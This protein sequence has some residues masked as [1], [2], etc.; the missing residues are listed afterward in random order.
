MERITADDMDYWV[1]GT[2]PALLILH[3]GGASAEALLG[4]A[5]LVGHG[6]RV[7]VPNLAGYGRSAPQDPNQPAMAAHLAVVE[8]AFALCDGPIDLIG[9]S[10]GGFMALRAASRQPERVRR[11]V[12]IEP[13]CFGSLHTGDPLDAAAL[14][15]DRAAI[16][17][18]VRLVD[19]HEVEA[20]VAA[21]I[22][23]WG[24]APWDK[25]PERIRARL[26]ALGRQ[27]RREAFE[28]SYDE[29]PATAYAALGDRTLLL[30]GAEAPLPARR[31]VTRLA[32]AMPGAQTETIAGA[33]HMAVVMQPNL[34]AEPV[35]QWLD[36]G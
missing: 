2:G 26:V 3:G 19:A 10:M 34:F 9:H 24:G 33:G 32:E 7:L 14:A 16:D 29:T 8:H 25:M 31:I 12:A 15:E 17:A 28:T 4:L 35:R 11:L 5:G 23:Y 22:N 13:M 18:L 27:L 20:G 36:A 1:G 21:F 6:Y 30:A